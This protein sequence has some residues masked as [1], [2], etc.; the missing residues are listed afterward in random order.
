MEIIVLGLLIIKESTIYEIRKIIETNF[1]AMS[2]NSMGSI[3]ATVKK[4]L[5][6][7]MITYNEFV[8]NSV[9]KKVYSVTTEG[10]AY[11]LDCV[12][13]PMRYKERSMELSKLF[14]MGFA[15]R[16]SRADLLNA[17]ISELKRE[18]TRLEGVRL[19]TKSVDDSVAEYIN[20]LNS[21]GTMDSF[22]EALNNSPLAENLK[23]IVLF[24]FAALDLSIAKIDFEIQWFEQFAAR[25]EG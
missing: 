22:N 17:Y 20:Y 24:Q 23:E 13:T 18:R 5:G 3:Q 4:L 9:N 14:F 15:P 21:S 19:S 7:R 16:D 10:K 11:F 12:S 25:L 2:S 1:S 6:N 8:E